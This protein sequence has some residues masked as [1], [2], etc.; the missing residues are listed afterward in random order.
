MALTSLS[1]YFAVY[2]WPFSESHGTGWCLYVSRE[3]VCGGGQPQTS[4]LVVAQ[5]TSVE[6]AWRLSLAR[7]ACRSIEK[8]DESLG[9]INNR[10][11]LSPKR[12]ALPRVCSHRERDWCT[13]AQLSH[14]DFLVERLL[15]VGGRIARCFLLPVGSL[16]TRGAPVRH[17]LAGG[18]ITSLC[19]CLET[20]FIH[21]CCRHVQKPHAP[22]YLTSSFTRFFR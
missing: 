13:H 7:P 12:P 4:L 1:L 17:L 19:V 2:F 8:K 14:K 5:H 3:C 20:Y 9:L 22:R 21:S 10:R 16:L 6:M 15:S 11:R 18:W